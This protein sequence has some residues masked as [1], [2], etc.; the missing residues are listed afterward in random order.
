MIKM[1]G[2]SLKNTLVFL[3]PDFT[4][5]FWT[6]H[7]FYVGKGVLQR[8][9]QFCVPCTPPNTFFSKKTLFIRFLT[10]I[11]NLVLIL[12]YEKY[13]AVNRLTR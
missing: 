5:L 7:G 10:H 6:F 4:Q 13:Q 11:S 12:Q 2:F 1:P 9:E 3:F 8:Y